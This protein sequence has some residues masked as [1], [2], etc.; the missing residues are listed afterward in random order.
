MVL[1]AKELESIVEL[2]KRVDE[3]SAARKIE[4]L[5]SILEIED[6]A[7]DELSESEVLLAAAEDELLS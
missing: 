4:E 2:S 7:A 6:V 1:A 3:D 5:V